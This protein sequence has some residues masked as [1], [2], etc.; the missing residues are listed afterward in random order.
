MTFTITAGWWLVP[1]ALSFVIGWLFFRER[2]PLVGAMYL[3][4]GG[5]LI[6]FVWMIYFAMGWALS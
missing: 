2:D 3:L 5:G 6:S 4:A 1:L